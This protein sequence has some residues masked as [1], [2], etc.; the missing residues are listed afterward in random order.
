[1]NPPGSDNGGDIQRVTATFN[2]TT[3]ELTFKM[4]V[5]GE[6][7][8]GFTLA[9]ND[10]PNP[11]GH[12]DEMAL[13]YFDNS[14]TEPVITAYNYNGQNN[15][16]SFHDTPLAS[17]L[18]VGSPFSGIEVTT[19]DSGNTVFCFTMDGTG[20]NQHSTGSDWTGVAFDES[21]GMWLH[22]MTGLE[23]SYGVDGYLNSWSYESEG[24]FDTANQVAAC[25]LIEPD[26][27]DEAEVNVSPDAVQ[28]E[29]STEYNVAVSGNVL[30]NDFDFDGDNLKVALA[31]DA[32]NGTVALSEDGTFT[33]VPHDG[34]V[35][36]DSFRYEVSDG[37]GGSDVA[38]VFVV[39][40]EPNPATASLVGSS[41][42]NEGDTGLYHVELD[43]AVSQETWLQIEIKDGS[44]NRVDHNA[45]G[46]DVIWGGWYDLR[47]GI[48][49]KVAGVVHGEV[50]NSTDPSS[51]TRDMV[52][53]PDNSWDFTAYQNGTVIQGDTVWVKIPAG[54]T[55]SEAFEIQTW[56]ERV[57]VDRDNGNSAGHVEG[58][59]D[60]TLCIVGTSDGKLID[61]ARDRIEV[62]IVDKS[63][64]D[65]VSPIGL[66]LNGDGEIGVTGESTARDR[67]GEVEIGRTVDFDIDND[68]DDDRIEWFAGDGDG[69]LVD[70]R[71]GNAAD[72]MDGGRLF[73]DEGGKYAN[74]YEKLSLLDSDGSGDL[75]GV[76][77][78]G[79]D[80]WV[81]DGDAVVED[82]EL[83]QLGEYGITS[84]SAGYEIVANGRGEQL[85]QS[86]A[87][88]VYGDR[89]LTEDVWFASDDEEDDR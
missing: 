80:I 63:T 57:T 55:A 67:I 46:Q 21:V 70:N 19:D 87:T 29:A 54:A 36:E 3:N 13:I 47:Y 35:G 40:E 26:E 10:G 74:G 32:G 78:I 31:E 33:Y 23:T 8:D 51:G 4:V 28:D 16:T 38:E 45:A 27:G 49:G 82:G 86:Y 6:D 22:P 68:G 37:R 9:I 65:Y 79:L 34:F 84:I 18:N 24:W 76:E 64:Y 20:I 11:K 30:G 56:K 1:M 88:D 48:G 85:M 52:G 73:G 7:T 83:H 50:P 71:D 69:I 53:T 77:L 42:I 62:D 5:S 25:E 44:A 81:D 61:V 75:T 2:D 66:D 15:F 14:G 41:V 72:D 12:G 60:F 39:V 58:T 43:H 17:S 89:V 59:E